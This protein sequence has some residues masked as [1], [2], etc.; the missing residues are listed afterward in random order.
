MTT[1][2]S[3]TSAHQSTP[4]QVGGSLP[5]EAQTYVIR[6]AD[7]DLYQALKAGEF[8]YVLN[9]RQMGKSSLRVRTMQRLTAEGMACAAIDVTKIGSQNMTP[10][11]WYASLIG[12]LAAAFNLGDRFNLRAWWRDRSLISPVQR[13]TDFMESV[14]LNEIEQHLVIFIDEV[15][16]LL[17]L[18]F[19]MDDFFAL[20]RA[21]YNSRVDHSSA[22]RLTFALFGVAT[23][24]DLIQDKQRTPFNIGRAIP[25]GGFEWPAAQVLASG[26]AEKTS[27]P[28]TVLQAILAWTGGQPFLTQKLCKL[29]V[30]T[31]EGIPLGQE[32]HWVQSLVETQ[33]IQNWE[34]QDEPE[35]LRTIRN[36]LLQNQHRAGRLLALCQTILQA[37]ATAQHPEGIE[38]DSSPEQMELRLSG[39]VHQVQ[40]R[41]QIRNNIYR[42]VFNLGWV[43][44]ELAKL[45]PYTEAF[46]AWSASQGQDQS[47]LLRG[48]ALQEALGW[49]STK[50]LSDQ[51]YQFLSA[52]QHA[53]KQEVQLNLESERQAKKAIEEAN[54]ILTQAHRK[55]RRIIQIAMAALA[56]VTGVSAGAILIGVRTS[57][58]LQE[59]RQGLALEQ[60]GVATLQQFAT[61]QLD[62]LQA[63]I[64][65]GQDLQSL[66]SAR[67]PLQD[68]PTVKPLFVLQTIL[69]NISEQNQWQGHQG[70]IN[71]GHFSPQGNDLVTA[72]DDGYVRV[73]RTT[74]QQLSQFQVSPE[75]S[76]KVWSAQF[77]GQDNRLIT[78]TQEGQIRLWDLSGR[79]RSEVIAT[80]GEVYSIRVTEQGDR[81]AAAN[82]QGRV[83][84]WDA[85][86]KQLAAFV[87]NGGQ[88]NS[89][90]FSGDGQ[91]LMTV[92]ENGQVQAWS[93]SGQLLNQ[94]SSPNNG[95]PA[96]NSISCA[97]LP[98]TQSTA[99]PE[100]DSRCVT[101]G[102]DGIIRLWNLKTGQSLNQWRGSQVPLYSVNFHPDGQRVITLS[103]DGAVRL[104]NLSGRQLAEFQGHEE[105]VIS[106][107]F[108]PNGQQLVTTGRDGTLHLWDLSDP[109]Q[110]S[111]QHQKTWSVAFAPWGE[112]LATTGQD[113][114]VR[115]WT[116][117]GEPLLS[118]DPQTAGTNA[119][120]FSPK[121]R[122]FATA[123][124]D[125]TIKI[126]SGSGQHL[127]SLK[128]AKGGLYALSY[129]PDGQSLAAVGEDGMVHL[130]DMATQR[131]R[132]FKVSQA[133][134]WS[135]AFSPD[136]QE[137]LTAGDEGNVHL[138]TLQGKKLRTLPTRQK[139]ITS[140]RFNPIAPLV[141]TAGKDGTVS[142]W[143]TEDQSQFT[144]QSHP[145]NI[146]TLDFSPDGQRLAVAGQD[147]VIRVWTTA[148]QQLAEYTGHQG[149]IYNLQFRAN[150]QT[151]A[152]VGDDDTVRI[153]QTQGLEQLL[154]RGCQWLRGYLALQ[155]DNAQVCSGELNSSE[156]R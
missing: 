77:L 63:A 142:L 18:S 40:G 56:V 22:Q 139:W 46:Q 62:A 86:G 51:D 47:R 85:S 125:G 16:S 5:V 74:G 72:G 42:A 35:H 53:E 155:P 6:Q 83:Y 115:L 136:G 113:G 103:E 87:A 33:V 76:S 80:I 120:T 38:I 82:A 10:E 68:Y 84:I 106:T 78:V 75:A 141:A 20:L 2:L 117:E 25:L 154:G 7:A 36:R 146:L 91:H 61:Q 137:L 144:F 121:Q 94:W 59:T 39:Y 27:H 101:V 111:G 95:R 73:W 66:V 100:Q 128:E 70:A 122:H 48:Q 81:I 116:L 31:T 58:N 130:W 102:A 8:C 90:S 13:L 135:I 132:Q 52:S 150:G 145:N 147:G 67:L 37:D 92:G 148:G 15:D 29:V 153:W 57:Q 9:S 45:R 50:S 17:S 99:N 104:W 138:W 79:P 156:P 97:P 126:W 41:L 143:N 19:P 64:A 119:V 152:S 140:A 108:S 107:D 69:D 49:A 98:Q 14:L 26:L 1:T 105:L 131:H 149:K 43:E 114:Q 109:L 110:W 28:D 118:V 96:L 30:S 151:L 54:Q 60:M 34:A 89:L 133:A 129:S 3:H 11:Q 134:V 23:P 55:A 123:G 24:S 32:T 112:Y 65:S 44:Q 93:Q 71:S 21:H 4:Y 127:R 88:V 12:A 124:Q